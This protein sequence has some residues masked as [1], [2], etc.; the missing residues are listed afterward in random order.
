[1]KTF[2]S[3]SPEATRK[4]GRLL[5]ETM[6][7]GRSGEKAQVIALTGDLGAGKTTFLKGLLSGLGVRR[8]ISSPTFVLLKRY[9]SVYHLDAYRLNNS[10]EAAGLGLE[11]IIA[12]PRSI[13]LVEWA[14]R[15]R[16][17]LP[18]GSVW[19]EFSYGDSERERRI[20]IQ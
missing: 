5:A 9:G 1:M 14:D 4:A 15:I 13:V 3:K 6:R 20:T 19:I 18:A 12:D 10:R 11:K 16:K 2:I 17:M 8:R 7:L